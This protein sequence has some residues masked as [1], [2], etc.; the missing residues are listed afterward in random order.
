MRKI[1]TCNCLFDAPILA[2]KYNNN[3]VR[4]KNRCFSMI[5]FDFIMI[6]KLIP[7]IFHV[8]NLSGKNHNMVFLN[9]LC[10]LQKIFVFILVPIFSMKERK[11]WI[12]C[13]QF[14]ELTIICNYCVLDSFGP[15]FV[16]L[17][18][19]NFFNTLSEK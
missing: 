4:F 16:R 3:F 17:L 15:K 10:N 13:I 9:I 19:S 5:K 18:L 12:M 6:V 11:K 1:Y 2:M 14:D 7:V 8:W